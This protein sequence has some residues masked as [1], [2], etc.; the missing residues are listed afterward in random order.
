MAEGRMLKKR[1][2][3]SKKLADLKTDSSRF[4]YCII[5]PHLDIK[6]RYEADPH[7]IMGTIVPYIKAFT[8]KKIQA[9]LEELH[10]VGL[11]VLYKINNNQFLQ[12][13]RFEDFQRLDP[14]REAKSEIAPPTQDQLQSKS[15]STPPEVKLSKVNISKVKYKDFV[16]LT[17]DQFNKLVNTYG[18]SIT[19]QYIQKLNNY[20]G[21]KG[22]K[23]KSHYHTILTW[24]NK[25][26][27]RKVPPKVA[28]PMVTA[29]RH[30]P[31]VA[32]LVSK[33]VKKMKTW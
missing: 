27:I 21:S 32:A 9:C 7:I 28:P 19:N 33:A 16:L 8:L 2:S 25:D 4:L 18:K 10:K 12:Y 15:I 20:I 1:L 11:I 30:D 3:K 22:A 29:K 17:L 6:G 26:N 14:T 13:T 31:E 24:C 5:Y 23:Y